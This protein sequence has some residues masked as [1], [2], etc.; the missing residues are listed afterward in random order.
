[1]AHPNGS[2][3]NVFPVRRS[4]GQAYTHIGLAGIDFESTTGEA[5]RATQGVAG[6]GVTPTIVLTGERNVH[7]RVCQACWG[8]ML[9]CTGE[10][11]GQAVAP[12]D[13]LVP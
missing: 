4:F 6:D 7:G 12:L 11:I 9:S 13:S 2:T 3:G 5:M 10:R 1:M 8:N